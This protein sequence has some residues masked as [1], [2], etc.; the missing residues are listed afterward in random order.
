MSNNGT[1]ICKRIYGEKEGD[2]ST[3]CLLV[4]LLIDTV[5]EIPGTVDPRSGD[6]LPVSLLTLADKMLALSR[7]GIVPAHD[8]LFQL[9][10]FL[11]K[12]IAD[13][14]DSPRE[15]IIRTHRMTPVQ[16][17]KSFDAES[18]KWLIRRPGSN[19]Y[20]KM[21]LSKSVLAVKREFV[22]DTAENRL[23]KAFSREL[24]GYLT[25][26]QTIFGN[27]IRDE[28]K[29]LAF[30]L[31]RWLRDE[32]EMIRSWN[33]MPPNNV[34]LQ[35]K[36]YRKIWD[37]WQMLQTMGNSLE[38][39]LKNAHEYQRQ[40]FFLVLIAVLRESGVK[41]T[42]IPVSINLQQSEF[43]GGFAL[44]MPVP[45]LHGFS[46]EKNRT[47]FISVELQADSVVIKRGQQ[48]KIFKFC[49]DCNIS[50]EDFTIPDLEGQFEEN[51]FVP[52]LIPSL[53]KEEW[54]LTDK[55]QPVRKHT[56]S[57]HTAVDFYNNRLNCISGG[58]GKTAAI[59]PVLGRQY[60]HDGV[61]HSLSL[62]ERNARYESD[63]CRTEMLS[64]IWTGIVDEK[65]ISQFS[66][67]IVSDIFE[68][69]GSKVK[70]A[71]FLLPDM[72]DDLSP[73]AKTL[74]LAIK[75][76]A[77]TPY[78]YLP[79][80]IAAV[81][82]L[83][84]TGK[85]KS[86]KNL[87]FC[88]A[89]YSGKK[90]SLT[91]VRAKNGHLS[92]ELEQTLP[93]TCG[94]IW[95][96]LPC[97]SFFVEK[98]NISENAVI[99]VFNEQYHLW[100][101]KVKSENIEIAQYIREL[102]EVG[103]D[104]K[105][106]FVP[107]S[108]DIILDH[109][110]IKTDSSLLTGADRNICRGAL[111]LD[112]LQKKTDIPLW[113]DV[114][115]LL[116]LT[117]R[118]GNEGVRSTSLI[119]E[120][121]E[122]FSAQFGKRILLSGGEHK[123]YFLPGKIEQ[124]CS[125]RQSDGKK[126]VGY[127]VR[128][129]LK[130]AP[131]KRLLCGLE[132]YYTYGAP[133]PYSMK[134]VPQ[135]PSFEP[136][137]GV[138]E[139]DEE[140]EYA[141]SAP[142][143]PPLQLWSDDSQN[144]IGFINEKWIKKFQKLEQCC[145]DPSPRNLA[146]AG[147]L[148]VTAED[149][150][151]YPCRE[152]SFAVTACYENISKDHVTLKGQI[153][154]SIRNDNRKSEVCYLHD[155]LD[156]MI[157]EEAKFIFMD[158]EFAFF[159][160]ENRKEI[161][162]KRSKIKQLLQKEQNYFITYNPAIMEKC[163]NPKNNAKIISNS[164]IR[165]DDNGEFIGG[166]NLSAM[167]IDPIPGDPIEYRKWVRPNGAVHSSVKNGVYQIFTDFIVSDERDPQWQTFTLYPP[168][169]DDARNQMGREKSFMRK[170][171][172]LLTLNGRRPLTN[173]APEEILSY[174]RVMIPK[175][176]NLL[177]SNCGND[178]LKLASEFLASC[179][180]LIPQEFGEWLLEC[181]DN[182]DINIP[183]I[184]Y[185]NALGDLEYQWQKELWQKIKDECKHKVTPFIRM[186]FGIAVGRSD[187]PLKNIEKKTAVAVL[188]SLL[189]ALKSTVQQLRDHT[190]QNGENYEQRLQ[191][192]RNSLQLLLSLLR[193][194]KSEDEEL[195]MLLHPSSELTNKFRVVID[196]LNML[197]L[198]EKLSILVNGSRKSLPREIFQYLEG[199]NPDELIEIQDEDE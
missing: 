29:H 195:R 10:D 133:E 171:F 148:K 59:Q 140:A 166:W 20:Q 16:Q 57:G 105:I 48:E 6:F 154:V 162:L 14:L 12:P 99:P 155:N 128:I 86:L 21:A 170:Q 120:N 19:A 52:Y 149:C 180:E 111:Y 39:D 79:V 60:W 108:G 23:F 125:I 121:H 97:R 71:T 102:C 142:L 187:V 68:Y 54:L 183:P 184:V 177:D 130:N 88:I 47:A 132:L 77:S 176:Q 64:H 3:A 66:T 95:E 89:D 161:R 85:Y 163:G 17:A 153:I 182:K 109:A 150:K 74:K 136:V 90:I 33:N 30:R 179:G 38:S 144:V 116:S 24:L 137:W 178:S 93:K 43:C 31:S 13:I 157:C 2:F 62:M 34:L 92:K 94:V 5:R 76:R 25:L 78:N 70:S 98:N 119:S 4:S 123:F 181:F 53:K 129:K 156:N 143:L 40:V 63:R 67:E 7:R 37:A 110:Y 28:E 141:F 139:R 115:P 51:F 65:R 159:K 173:E 188:N 165:L 80:S 18:L 26:R 36:N 1:E 44:K 175:F 11:Q 194:R 145:N 58:K 84:Q 42:D 164:E 50:F 199:T 186:G 191:E 134:F 196:D 46:Q 75:S 49:P 69:L 82:A 127:C 61:E 118:D 112:E 185:G 193:L 15:K 168:S 167:G 114:L 138:L 100:Y 172:K 83:L 174:L 160:T 198:S 22:Q 104:Y 91:L 192:C 197:D 103:K 146:E 122:P 56:T 131:A 87:A 158:K 72:L 9:T 8:R 32:A 101:A 107:V 147:L 135:D 55:K 124:K 126:S 190:Q 189:G 73:E 27:E 151:N 35:D 96:R 45:V 41:F 106:I 117:S 81:F 169:A 113:T 152:G